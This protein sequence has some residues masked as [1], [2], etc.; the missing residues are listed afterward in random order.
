MSDTYWQDLLS[1]I[2]LSIGN[3]I[4]GQRIPCATDGDEADQVVKYAPRN[5][6]RLYSF[7]KG[8]AADI[9]AAVASA[10]EAF[11]D[12]RWRTLALAQRQAVLNK[13]ADLIEADKDRFALYESMDVGKTI[14]HALH[15]DLNRVT[16]ELRSAAAMASVLMAPSGADQ[17]FFSYQRR[18]PVGVVG[19][20]AGWNFPLTLAVS[21]MAPALIMGNSLVL[22]PSEFTSLSAQHLAVLA[23]EAGVP[24]GVFNVVHGVGA[25]V[26]AALVAHPDVDLISFVGSSATGKQIMASAAH[27]NMKRVILECGGKSPYLVFDDC[28][29]DLDFIAEDIVDTA[30]PNQGALCIAG[31]RLLIQDTLRDRLLPLIIEK[32]AAIKAKDPLS[33]EASFGA[34]VNEA[35]MEKVLGYI[36]S[37]KAEGA[38]LVLGGERVY[39]DGDDSIKNAFYIEPTI[40]DQVS[41]GAKIAQEEIFGPVLSVIT[42]SDEAEAIRL[43]NDSCFGLASY[44]A[45]TDLGRAQRLGERL[46][47]G[48]LVVLGTSQPSGGGI[49]TSSDKHRQSGQGYSGGLE[50]LAAYTVSTTAIVLT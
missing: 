44:A 46:N 48:L 12:G 24:P 36:D 38:E 37:G 29:E 5:G 4:N 39:P 15:D 28:P 31:T 6:E 41:P 43:A 50:G 1:T 16:G 8:S 30:F 2:D 22:K 25:T 20:I 47:A 3:V 11:D 9:D 34:L 42:F 19:G 32:A 10:R 45:T 17:G 40:F 21:K 49:S 13:L 26:G 35:H 7:P 33:S 14:N 23:L 27:S 18:K